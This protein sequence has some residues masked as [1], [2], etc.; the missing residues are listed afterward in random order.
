[1]MPGK[2]GYTLCR[3]IKSAIQTDHIAVIL[4]TAKAAHESVIEGLSAGADD[5]LTKPFHLDELELRINNILKRQEKLRLFF[6]QQLSN[7]N[8]G[9]QE[10]EIPNDFI[11]QLYEILDEYLDDSSFNVEKLAMNAH[12]SHRTL[13]RKLSILTGLSANELIKQ[14]RLKKSIEF[15]RSGHNVSETAYSVGFETHSHFTT[16]FKAFFGVTPSEYVHTK[17][18]G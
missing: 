17:I 7:P 11:K 12:V 5:Y 16:S 1:M 6:Q 3:E 4:L 18:S 8:T 2:D 14:Y 15:L 9:I 13:N 10:T